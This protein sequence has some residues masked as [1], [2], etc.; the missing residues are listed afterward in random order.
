VLAVGAG[1]LLAWASGGGQSGLFPSATRSSTSAPANSVSQARLDPQ[2]ISNQNDPAIVDVTSVLGDSGEAAG[3]GMVLTPTGEILTN[4]HVIAGATSITVKVSNRAQSYPAKVVGYDL[5]DDVA[6]LQ[7][8]G[9]SGLPTI[10]LGNSSQVSV[11]DGVVAIGNA[12]NRPG[13]PTVTEGTVTALGKSINVRS[14]TGGNTE[15][16]SNLIEVDAQ[17]EPGNSGGPLF[18]AAGKVIGMNTAASTGQIPVGG[19][20]DG[21]AIPVNDAL[22]I[23]HQIE[24][25]RSSG[26]TNVGQSGFLGVDVQDAGGGFGFGGGGSGVVVQQVVSGSPADS[27]GIK[28]GDTITAVNGQQVGSSTSLT[29][30]I[31][32]KHPGDAVRISWVDQNGDTHDANVRLGTRS[33]PA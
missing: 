11:G 24:S 30:L 18:N 27:A 6:V 9:A 21:F 28:A 5:I 8:Q 20:N 17:L 22:N 25:G 1:G 10:P 3:T 13:A 19:T 4:N 12:F 26:N 2:A 31:S 16:L 7:A 23:V 14:D 32:S 29:Q 15:Q 33:S